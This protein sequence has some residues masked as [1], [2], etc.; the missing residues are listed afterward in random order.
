MLTHEEAHH[1][2]HVMHM[3]VDNEVTVFDG[4]GSEM[5]CK[6][7]GVSNYGVQLEATSEPLRTSPK[8]QITLAQAITKK[9]MDWI[10]QKA[11]ELGA[12][13]FVPLLSERTIVQ[14]D[15]DVSARLKRWQT[16]A[17][18]ACKQ[19]GNNWLPKVHAPQSVRDYLTYV[20]GFDLRLVASLQPDSLSLKEI[21]AK[22]E[23][24]QRNATESNGSAVSCLIL[25]GP[26]GDFTLAEL[27]VATS[28]GCIP[29]SLG[30][31]TLRAETASLYALSVLHHEL[32]SLS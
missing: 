28:A 2:I 8:H 3:R 22:S 6:I 20:K 5:Q 26:E 13:A 19:S 25:V 31:L 12:V 29:L 18:N 16:I 10:V 30:P 15:G 23:L 1:C 4:R 14:I 9:N 32:A 7:T 27:G 11:T 17:L 24:L 21:I